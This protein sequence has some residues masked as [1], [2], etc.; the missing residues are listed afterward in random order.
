[1]RV[2]VL[3]IA[4]EFEVVK[5][6]VSDAVLAKVESLLAQ[7]KC[8]GCKEVIP[9]GGRRT[10]GLCGA[11]YEAARQRIKRNA[12]ARTKMVK[13]GEMLGGDG[14]GR[15]CKNEFTKKMRAKKTVS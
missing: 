6:N 14:R 8:L 7:S 11:C 2:F 4:T 1:M 10:K 5:V 12:S 15:P 9:V 3:R 13:A